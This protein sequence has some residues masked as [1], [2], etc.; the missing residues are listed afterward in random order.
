MSR[1]RARRRRL[2]LAVLVGFAAGAFAFGAALG[3]GTPKRIEVA[4]T[5][6]ASQLAGERIVTGLPGTGISPRLRT[7]IAEGRVAGVVLFD[8]NFPTR[9][10]GRGLISRLQ[11][12]R[13]PPALR[14]PLLVMVDQ[15]G[16]LVKRVDGA[17]TASALQM[18]ER[19]PDFSREQG[20][21]TAAN[22][23]GIGINVDLA[24]VLDVARPGGTIAETERGFGSTAAAVATTAIPFATA[25]QQGGVAATAK[26]FPGFGA[27]R[28]NTDFAVQRIGL[29]RERL[30]AVDEA[31]YRSFIAAGGD[32]VMLS[33]AIYPAFSPDPAAFARPIA[34][35]ELRRR[36]G[37]AGVSITDAL[38]T[39]AVED[40]GGPAKAGIAAARAGTDLLLF[41]SLAPAERTWQALVGKLRAGALD[42]AE[43][44]ASAQRVLDLRARMAP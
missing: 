10:A 21:R 32:L 23:R 35:G 3:D 7:A 42:R 4:E 5:L 38:E 25:L 44:E 41:T 30:R 17:P 34:T 33:T 1:V 6:S 8:A 36:L 18:G 22:L 31:P 9:A 37:F 29:S 40:F 12:I 39:V 15:E 13:R 24:P 43:F 14:N 20:R 26:H 27:A 16:G 11:A 2:S 28:E 19:G